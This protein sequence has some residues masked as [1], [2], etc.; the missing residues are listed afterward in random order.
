MKFITEAE[1]RSDY[2]KE[3]FAV[4]TDQ[5][6]SRLTPG[7]RQYLLDRGVRITVS[8]PVRSDNLP[9]SKPIA[10]VV[11]E[12]FNLAAYVQSPEGET[13][14][15]LQYLHSLLQ[16]QLKQLP[17]AWQPDIESLIDQ[18]SRMISQALGGTR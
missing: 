2:Q 15:G 4:Y 18:L 1:I 9:E 8:Q 14:I 10:P 5:Q 16:K 7:A 6:G 3:P 13:I 12:P 11:S 17:Q